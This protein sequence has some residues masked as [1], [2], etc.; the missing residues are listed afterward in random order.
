[1]T[2]KEIKRRIREA[3]ANYA[4]VTAAT[5]FSAIPR[6]ATQGKLYEAWVLAHVLEQLRLHEGM[7]ARL[8]AGTELRMRSSPGPIDPRFPRIEMSVGNSVVGEIWTDIEWT[9]L[10]FSRSGRTTLIDCDYHELDIVFTSRNPNRYPAHDEILL[11]IEC[12]NTSYK[13]TSYKKHLLREILG[14]RRELSFLREAQPTP[15][16]NWPRAFVP[17]APTSCLMVFSTDPHISRLAH[18][19]DVF[20][21]NFQYLD[22]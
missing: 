15:F 11:G 1:V 18:S 14:V 13:N 22:M 20:G 5:P 21:I 3:F 8:I 17:A 4:A 6:R 16:T 7:M 2:Q 19:P 9:T 10:S 12:K